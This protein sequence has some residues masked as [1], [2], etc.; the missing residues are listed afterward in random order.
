M[1]TI[2]EILQQA[3]E[4]VKN[5]HGVAL[6]SVNYDF[7]KKL[8]G[9]THFSGVRFEAE[10]SSK[11]AGVKLETKNIATKFSTWPWEAQV[12]EDSCY[13]A[14]HVGYVDARGIMPDTICSRVYSEHDA[15][16]IAAA[17]ELYV[18]LANIEN[19]DGRI[20]KTIWAMRNAALAKA[21]GES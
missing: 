11:A 19:D 9:E 18:A 7:I 21:R 6:T 1:Q 8:N 14:M 5:N 10:R 4:D 3:F 15:Y 2:P 16:L 17:P 13:G 12:D 20:P